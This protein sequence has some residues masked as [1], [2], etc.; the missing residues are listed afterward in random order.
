[1][2]KR[3]LLLTLCLAM[4]CGTSSCYFMSQY[5]QQQNNQP[6]DPVTLTI[7]YPDGEETVTVIPGYTNSFTP[8][9]IEGK[10]LIGFY[11]Q[12][13]AVGKEYFNFKGKMNSSWQAENPTT[14]YAI[15]EDA[16]YS[17]VFH[18]DI[19]WDEDPVAYAKGGGKGR[20]AIWYPKKLE[21]DEDFFRT[22][23]SNPNLEVTVWLEVDVK[24]T[25]DARDYYKGKTIISM[26]K[27][28]EEFR[29]Q[30]YS[31]SD[32]SFDD[33]THIMIYDRIKAKQLFAS[34]SDI[35]ARVV[36]SSMG[37]GGLVKN[38]QISITIVDPNE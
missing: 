38:A 10:T 2:L 35:Y 11:G 8:K 24:L 18:S 3:I 4:M 1:M 19:V 15:Y 21:A 32:L 33:Y 37:W 16:D 14:L 7:I 23:Y 17:L 6:K 27:G 20:T 29:S 9:Y 13:S 25:E 22:I 31:V 12:D 5:A 28:V 30:E 36:W 26:G 34:D